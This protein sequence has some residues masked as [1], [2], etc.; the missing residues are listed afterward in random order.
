MD[1]FLDLLAQSVI[2]QGLVTLLLVAVC[3]TLA[4]QS[5][6]IPALISDATLLALGYYFGSKAQQSINAY[7]R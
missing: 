7:R 6:E 3:S 2:V 4:L 1:R 5:K